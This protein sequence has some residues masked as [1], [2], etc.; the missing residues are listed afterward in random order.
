MT[1]VIE[2]VLYSVYKCVLVEVIVQNLSLP[3]RQ[4]L[5]QL[6]SVAHRIA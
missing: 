4:W 1:H 6:S 3:P 5:W 2:N